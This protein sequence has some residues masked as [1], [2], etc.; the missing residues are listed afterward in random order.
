MSK[1]YIVLR[2]EA[3]FQIANASLK[4]RQGQVG[5][6]PG[7]RLDPEVIAEFDD[8]EDAKKYAAKAGKSYEE[9]V[10]NRITNMQSLAKKKKENAKEPTAADRERAFQEAKVLDK[11][12]NLRDPGAAEKELAKVRA[13]LAAEKSKSKKVMSKALLDQNTRVVAKSV[14]T[15]A[16]KGEIAKEDVETLI[17]EEQKGKKRK[18]VLSRLKDLVKDDAIFGRL[19]K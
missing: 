7:Y 12:G 8:L 10:S 15:A 16:K 2:P 5:I 13:E 19:V 14:E 18:S 17:H 9:V 11:E 6:H 3:P 1:K 4:L